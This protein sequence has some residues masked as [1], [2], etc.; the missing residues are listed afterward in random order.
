V[1]QDK[2]DASPTTARYLFPRKTRF[3]KFAAIISKIDC[4]VAG[5]HASPMR[6]EE[7]R[8]N[9]YVDLMTAPPPNPFGSGAVV[10]AGSISPSPGPFFAESGP[11]D[12]D[13]PN[14]RL[15]VRSPS[16]R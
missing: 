12:D 11:L 1:Q 4:A 3:S 16:R 8:C 6:D 15:L 14:R 13:S 7:R 2:S 5:H 10:R 9:A